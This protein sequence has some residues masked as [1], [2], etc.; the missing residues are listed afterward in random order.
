M[1][2]LGQCLA[3]PPTRKTIQITNFGIFGPSWMKLG[4]K[5]QIRVNS[6]KPE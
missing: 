1:G 2:W 6:N 5:V 3:T 4:R